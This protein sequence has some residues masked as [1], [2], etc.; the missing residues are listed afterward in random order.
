MLSSDSIHGAPLS[1]GRPTATSARLIAARA[2]ETTR[3]HV[4]TFVRLAIA[5]LLFPHGAQH[6]L[7]W[8]GG[9]GFHGTHGW[10]TSTLGFPAPAA[11]AAI[12]TEIAAPVALLLGLGGRL[13]ALGTI[14]I[15]LGAIRT[16]WGNG[17]FMNWFG[18][19]PAGNE[20][21][22]YH[23]LMITLCLVVVAKGSGAWSLDRWLRATLGDRGV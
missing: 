7:G 21:F 14:G 18:G 23:L 15:M 17:F 16:H 3:D 19:L 2:L 4:T 10:M 20:G 8:F 5:S 11:T 6:A 22:E 12:L 1:A 9:Y 13:A